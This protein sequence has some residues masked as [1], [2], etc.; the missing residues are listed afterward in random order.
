VHFNDI[1][2]TLE[3]EIKSVP[4]VVESGLFQGRQVEILVPGS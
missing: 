4:G 1:G 3:R 2:P